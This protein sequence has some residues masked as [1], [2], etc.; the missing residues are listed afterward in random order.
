MF[1][2]FH[3]GG[4][5]RK[6]VKVLKVEIKVSFSVFSPYFYLIYA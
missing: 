2:K 1:A 5:V 3:L 6:L 4:G